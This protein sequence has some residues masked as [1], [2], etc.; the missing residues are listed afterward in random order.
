MARITRNRAIVLLT[1]WRF[2]DPEFVASMNHTDVR[3]MPS[4]GLLLH[5]PAGVQQ[6][7]GFISSCPILRVACPVTAYLDWMAIRGQSAGPVFL[8]INHRGTLDDRALHPLAVEGVLRQ[9]VLGPAQTYSSEAFDAPRQLRALFFD[10]NVTVRHA[11]ASLMQELVQR[12][13]EPHP[14]IDTDSRRASEATVH[15]HR[16]QEERS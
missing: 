5:K 3:H 15:W 12:R 14:H 6:S 2:L 4:T 11:R 9:A 10:R 7:R 8:R 1:F 16:E 13:F